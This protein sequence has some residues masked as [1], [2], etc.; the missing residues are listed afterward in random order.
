MAKESINVLTIDGGGIRGLLPA[1]IL[2]YVENKLSELYGKETKL[3]EHFDYIAGTSTGGILT[4]L[5][6]YP[7]KD[8]KPKY[9]AQDASDLYYNHGSN[10][11]KK[12]LRWV[13]TFGGAFSYRY[14][15][16]YLETMFEKYFGR[17]RIKEAVVPF[18]ITSVDTDGRGL[19][20]FKSYKGKEE[21]KHNKEYKIAARATSAAPS[22]FKPVQMFIDHEFETQE[23]C[24]I[25]GGMGINNPSISSLIEIRKI[26]PN[27]KKVNMLSLGTGPDDTS[28]PYKK[29][30]NWGV[31]SADKIFSVTLT[32]TSKAA[33]YQVGKDYEDEPD[34]GIYLRLEPESDGAS[35]KMDSASKKNLTALKKAGQ[36]SAKEFKEDIDKFLEL[37]VNKR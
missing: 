29:A 5:Y 32:S 16:K 26:F 8:G 12:K 18:M 2:V 7:D 28:Y 20:L 30:K 37:T 34:K 27:A 10:I 24:L 22:Y 15:A 1:E 6:T 9:S 31:L 3:A 13:L 33:D 4:C 25:D 35:S 19:Y 17:T 11:F 23:L 14:N 21:S 36:K